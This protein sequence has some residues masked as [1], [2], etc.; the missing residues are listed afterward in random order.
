MFNSPAMGR[1]AIERNPGVGYA[2]D[3]TPD[4]RAPDCRTRR[5]ERPFRHLLCR[6]DD[7]PSRGLRNP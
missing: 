4:S 5:I 6:L 3:S 1:S 2:V 7:D